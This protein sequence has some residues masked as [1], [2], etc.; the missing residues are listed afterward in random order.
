MKKLH[1]HKLIVLLL[2]IIIISAVRLESFHEIQIQNNIDINNEQR[3]N[4]QLKSF[5][6]IRQ[7]N[8]K[9]IK[10][11]E[12]T[13]AP[14]HLTPTK[15]NLSNIVIF[16][17]F[18]G[19][20]EYFDSKDSYDGIFNSDN[21]NSVYYYFR[22]VSYNKISIKS[23]FFPI[24]NSSIINFYED[25]YTREYYQP[26]DSIT[27][28]IGYTEENKGHRTGYLMANAINYV[29]SKI[30]ADMKIDSDGDGYVDCITFIITGTSAKW[31]L[32]DSVNELYG[33]PFYINNKLVSQNIII[34]DNSIKAYGQSFPA[35]GILG[36]MGFEIFGFP[37]PDDIDPIG[38]WG[39]RYLSAMKE[40]MPHMGAYLKYRYGKWI[41]SIPE[42]T[43]SGIYSIRPI[44]SATDNCYKI[45]SPYSKNEYFIVEY[46]KNIGI[47][48]SSLG[49]EGLLIYRINTIKDGKGNENVPPYEFYIYRPDGTVTNNGNISQANYSEEVDRKQIND[50]TNPS[51]FLSDGTPGGL[52]IF[53][54][55]PIGDSISF[56]VQI[57][58]VFPTIKVIKP[59]G[60]ESW[61][62]GSIN[63]IMWT[64]TGI[65]GKIRIEYST[66]EGNTYTTVIPSTD[67]TGIYPWTVPN[68]PSTKCL[69]KISQS[70]TT[71][72]L[73]VSDSVFSIIPRPPEEYVIISEVNPELSPRLEEVESNE[74]ITRYYKIVDQNGNSLPPSYNQDSGERI[75]YNI[76]LI[77]TPNYYIS[78]P[79]STYILNVGR[80]LSLRIDLKSIS[81]PSWS[82]IDF[83]FPLYIQIEEKNIKIKSAPEP[84][85]FKRI[86]SKFTKNFSIFSSMS[87]GISGGFGVGAKWGTGAVS[88]NAAELSV[89]GKYGMGVNIEVDE[90]G[91]ISRMSR[92]FD[93]SIGAGINFPSVEAEIWGRPIAKGG[94][95]DEVRL[96]SLFRNEIEL[97]YLTPDEKQIVAAGFLLESF[98]QAGILTGPVTIL[99]L[100]A[101]I[102][103]IKEYGEKYGDVLDKAKYSE[104]SSA[105][106]EGK[107]SA[108]GG[109]TTPIV[110]LSAGGEVIGDWIVSEKKYH[111]ENSIGRSIA[112]NFAC[113][114]S[115]DFIPNISDL[116]KFDQWLSEFGSSISNSTY[117][118]SSGEVKKSSNHE[119]EWLYDSITGE[120]KKYNYMI[121]LGASVDD[122]VSKFET[123]DYVSYPLKYEVNNSKILDG[124]KSSSTIASI[125][126]AKASD[127]KIDIVAPSY[128]TDLYN[129]FELAKRLSNENNIVGVIKTYGRR[130]AR[131]EKIFDEE[132]S[133]GI[134]IGAGF[135]VSFGLSTTY[136]NDIMQSLVS[137]YYYNGWY[138]PRHE[139]E[140]MNMSPSGGLLP[141]LLKN[142]VFANLGNKII[143]SIQKKI[144]I[145]NQLIAGITE[146][147]DLI[148]STT[149]RIFGKIIVTGLKGYQV[150]IT[151]F[152]A[153]LP[154]Y[155][156]STKISVQ[157]K[158]A[159]HSNDNI[160]L[161][162]YRELISKSNITKSLCIISK[163]FLIEAKNENGEIIK[164][165]SISQKL[166]INISEQDL[167]ENGFSTVDRSKAKI[168]YYDA[169]SKTWSM[170]QIQSNDGNIAYAEIT[171]TGLYC[172]GI[173]IINDINDP[174]G[175]GLLTSQ[176]DKNGNGY[177]DYGETDPYNWDTDGDGYNDGEE[178][179]E[180]TNPLDPKS[181]PEN[182]SLTILVS[183]GGTVDPM[184]GN[185][186]YKNNTSIRLTSFEDPSYRFLS[187]SGDVPIGKEKDNP[188]MIL[189]DKN[190]SIKANFVNQS[191]QSISIISP[192]GGEKWI[193]GSTQN[194]TWTSSGVANVKIEYSTNGGTIWT[195][196]IASTGNTES[197]NWIIP[198]TPSAD[199]LV[200]VSDAYNTAVSD[201]SNGVFSIIA[202][203]SI[204]VTAP[205]GGESW[206]AGTSRN[207]NWTSTSVANVKIEYSTDG[208]SKYTTVITLTANTGNYSWTVP[209]TP[210]TT[211]L[212][213]ISETATGM[214]V[215]TSDAVFSIVA[216][217]P[218]KI[219]LSKNK[220]N[221]GA[222]AGGLKTQSLSV[223]I[224]NAGGGTLN[225]TAAPK[226]SWIT[227]TPAS[228]TG[229][230]TISIGVNP[231]GLSSGTYTGTATVAAAG[232]TNSPQTI[233]VNLRIYDGT[234]APIG[235]VD[236]PTDGTAGIEGSVPVTGWVVDDIEV[237][238]VKIYRDP[239]GGEGAGPNGY[240]YIGDVV[241]VEGA[242]PD[243]EQAYPAYPL[244]YRAGWGYMMLTN[245]LPN[246][247]NGTFR[248][249][250]IATDKEGKNT[251]LGSKTITCDNAHAT[252]PFG[253]IDVPSQGGTASG[254]AYINFAW[255]LATKPKCIPADGSTI[256][257]WV[258]GLPI[259]HPS[260]SYYRVDIATLFP[261]YCNANGA[262]G[263]IPID[264]TKYTNGVHTIVW[265]ATDSGGVNNGFGSRY[266][267]IQN[268]GS[269][270][271]AER[272]DFEVRAAEKREKELEQE[273]IYTYP[274]FPVS[275]RRGFDKETLP[276]AVYP[277]EN[278]QIK[279]EIRELER[280]EIKLSSEED[281]GSWWGFLKVGEELRPL[282]IGSSIDAAQGIFSWLPGA[283]FI[284]EYE[285]VFVNDGLGGERKI[286]VKVIIKPRF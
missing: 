100:D 92:R 218:P 167:L 264:T 50:S 179:K 104:S 228:G 194:I 225:W 74:V 173:E 231:S 6:F 53:D 232:A 229:T 48:E 236:T 279:V 263:Y 91:E 215:D 284:G 210:S 69:I 175:D 54:I 120:A 59:N 125:I 132:I 102:D 55:G 83:S 242:R 96:L 139:Y 159:A 101:I 146:P 273:T 45:R 99:I 270:I 115:L 35:I 138:R 134:K 41:D 64:S 68:T 230:G 250:A 164:K 19:E 268:T 49:G 14:P 202:A 34:C 27:N 266:F 1:F 137:Y 237:V 81:N 42:I 129:T 241:F 274:R 267:T 118:I 71:T 97:K 214:P 197:F 200:R 148:A 275:V 166:N 79:N 178:N 285:F 114:M 283:G 223:M 21:A 269:A 245:F 208:G 277:D 189:L 8:N 113:N 72:I 116:S 29:K 36:S 86:P 219:S 89:S 15:G 135:D 238:S 28:P 107:I 39:P 131:I 281:R 182:R 9:N 205:N 13:L 122:P 186:I 2:F 119:L 199:C 67:N 272:I 61:Q 174:D 184:L 20:S 187:W 82:Y 220:L 170:M 259:G 195:T 157:R 165:F 121:E 152:S 43:S 191:Y 181:V 51:S 12:N 31:P 44:T 112:S 188:L 108:G 201:L 235:V 11:N 262:I 56:K 213:R 211:C 251:L 154:I 130:R 16:V 40:A 70:L 249:Y 24:S 243:V 247:G 126:A 65:V 226:I 234:N 257:A 128:V 23:S 153:K 3:Q 124:L 127:R 265:S 261:G 172:L 73:D 185:H 224:S 198:S 78:V 62:V 52:N 30:P 37:G 147:I 180:T 252:L 248:I 7:D 222:Q 168:F 123:T 207:I 217:T 244:N 161:N 141:L 163:I 256:I 111:K 177:I 94:I 255:V 47:F 98:I 46:R 85:A 32:A 254:S 17:K 258:D 203:P 5:N 63:D 221:F 18:S 239:V 117:P 280:V 278:G 80:M 144:D 58:A 84:F 25:K 93:T 253:A 246:S 57:G 90:N 4:I 276:E 196:V 105:G 87:A 110:Q 142:K 271:Q 240:V 156:S 192:N 169:V 160:T 88:L 145:W 171:N 227:A 77:S 190:I 10:L 103:W 26:Y 109:I 155:T 33:E 162:N 193:G 66:D 151:L 149:K 158:L 133:I 176:E 136:A 150:V 95:E 38:T 140:D 260:Y 106:I 212:V 143:N 75:N 204:A 286:P 22:E 282:P 76:S 216:P 183:P 233:T 206:I 209:N 60:G